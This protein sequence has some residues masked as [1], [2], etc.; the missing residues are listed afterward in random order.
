MPDQPAGN[1]FKFSRNGGQKH[2]ERLAT[3]EEL[4]EYGPAA[5]DRLTEA[6]IL[7]LFEE[8]LLRDL[9]KDASN[10][11]GESNSGEVSIETQVR[12]SAETNEWTSEPKQCAV[13][14]PAFAETNVVL[15]EE[16]VNE[17]LEAAEERATET[18]AEPEVESVELTEP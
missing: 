15:Q 5:P 2:V 13:D 6:K 18:S 10:R 11:S 12:N 17:A 9:V 16:A 4:A 8:Q 1:I 14:E 7:A 3:A